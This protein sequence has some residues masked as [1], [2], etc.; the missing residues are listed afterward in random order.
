MGSL[1]FNL[2]RL[3]L[4]SYIMSLFSEGVILPIYAVFVQRIGGDVFDAGI[5]LGIFLMGEGIFTALIH[6]KK[7]RT[8]KQKINLMVLGWFVWFAGILFYL[9]ISNKWTLF[10]AQVLLAL[11]NALADPI[12]DEEFAQN[13]KKSTEEKEWGFFEGG[14]SFVDGISAIAGGAIAAFFGFNILIY[15]MVL[16]AT[17]SCL[18]ILRYVK[19][20]RKR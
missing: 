1:K 19:K 4:T 14:K 3:L 15:V 7:K 8:H 18:I 11:G 16:T 6:N 9:F 12:Y 13:T 2:N 10:A 20:V 5:A 17:I